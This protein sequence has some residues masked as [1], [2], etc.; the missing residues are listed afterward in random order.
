MPV[1]LAPGDYAGWLDPAN[2]DADGLLA[3]LKPTLPE[4]WALHPVSRQVNSP[5]NDGPDLLTPVE[6]AG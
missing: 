6:A 2:E 4:N 5:R 3:L 1:I